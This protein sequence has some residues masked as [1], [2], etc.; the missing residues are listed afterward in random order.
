M[1]G[2]G[3]IAAITW[4]VLALLGR[5]LPHGVWLALFLGIFAVWLPAVL[6]ILP[7]RGKLQEVGGI[8]TFRIIFAGAPLWMAALALL[9]LAYAVVNFLLATG[10]PIGSVSD[11]DPSFQRVASGHAIAFYAAA[12]TI[13]Y[14]ASIRADPPRCYNGHRLMPGQEKCA[15]CGA[16]AIPDLA[17]S[18][19]GA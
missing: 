8:Q 13:L 5:D 17:R 4:H 14:A 9:A 2:L 15:V 19:P 18:G 12:M 6:A 16:K 3:L 11:R 1:S 7:L 10:A